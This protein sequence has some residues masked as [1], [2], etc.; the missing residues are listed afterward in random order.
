M[1]VRIA[2]SETCPL[3]LLGVDS[4]IAR[5]NGDHYESCGDQETVML[6]E[7]R[8]QEAIKAAIEGKPILTADILR[9]IKK[10]TKAAV[11]MP[12]EQLTTGNEI[13]ALQSRIDAMVNECDMLK[14]K[15]ESK[16]GIVELKV[17]NITKLNTDIESLQKICHGARSTV[18][19]LNKDV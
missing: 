3:C 14:R 4:Y 10:Y 13:K 16:S 2:H 7:Q 18:D 17:A 15:V 1:T 19:S 9:G 5:I 6:Q 11:S 12:R 8:Y